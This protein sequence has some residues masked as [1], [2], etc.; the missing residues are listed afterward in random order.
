MNTTNNLEK[1]FS[2]LPVQL[3]S[4]KVELNELLLAANDV[5]DLRTAALKISRLRDSAYGGN[6][7]A[8]TI[9]DNLKPLL[10][11]IEKE[12]GY[13]KDILESATNTSF[14]EAAKDNLK[15]SFNKLSNSANELGISPT[16]LPVYKDYQSALSELKEYEE[17]TKDAISIT[18]RILK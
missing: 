18:K 3:N 9:E 17:F 12:K 14:I 11:T 10:Q 8:L 4:E 15:S 1:I 5:K 16:K 7:D 13:A 2:K 6:K